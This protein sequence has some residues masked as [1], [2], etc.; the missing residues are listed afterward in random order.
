VDGATLR[1]TPRKGFLVS[2]TG[3]EAGTA[4]AASARRST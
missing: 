4:T 1:L 3:G 2:E